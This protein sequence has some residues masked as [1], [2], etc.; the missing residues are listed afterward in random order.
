MSQEFRRISPADVNT[1][2][3]KVI[4]ERLLAVLQ[5]RQ[6]G[7]CMRVGD[8]DTEVMLEIAANLCRQVGAAAQVHVLSRENR[9]GG[10]APDHQQQACGIAQSSGRWR[11]AS[12]AAGFCS[13]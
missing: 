6:P 3:Q 1:E 11:A 12:A 13:Q 4:E 9:N 2:L 8:L 10:F 5:T 7:H